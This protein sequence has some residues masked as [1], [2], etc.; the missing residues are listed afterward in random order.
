M[1]TGGSVAVGG[2]IDLWLATSIDG[3]LYTDNFPSTNFTGTSTGSSPA[4]RN[5]WQIASIPVSVISTVY[6]FEDDL[7]NLSSSLP[8]YFGLIVQNN[9]GGALDA[10]YTCLIQGCSISLEYA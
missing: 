7:L 8:K 6:T 2:T 3:S 10:N 4:P 5:S 1:K 9:T